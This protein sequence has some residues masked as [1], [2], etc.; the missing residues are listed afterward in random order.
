M[1]DSTP[2]NVTIVSAAKVLCT[3][4]LISLNCQLIRLHLLFSSTSNITCPP[5]YLHHLDFR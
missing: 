1:A 5:C 3:M 4:P 2:S